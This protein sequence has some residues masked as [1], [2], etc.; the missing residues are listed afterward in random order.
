MGKDKEKK[1]AADVTLNKIKFHFICRFS[2]TKNIF[3][4]NAIYDNFVI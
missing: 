3:K 1:L 4:N 2:I